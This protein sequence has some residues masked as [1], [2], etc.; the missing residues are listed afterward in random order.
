MEL[1]VA[2]VVVAVLAALAVPAYRVYAQR[3]GRVEAMRALTQI[4]AAQ[5]KFFIQNG[6]YATAAELDAAPPAGLGLPT[7]TETG[8]YSVR[9]AAGGAPDSYVASATPA[10]GHGQHDDHACATFSI[11]QAG[12]KSALDS[13]SGDATRDC[14]K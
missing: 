14:W 11:D 9:I 10:A 4:G 8:L 12:R 5:E 3:A 1:L 13:S 6:R 7:V 2:M